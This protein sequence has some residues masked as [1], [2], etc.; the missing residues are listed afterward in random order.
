MR[1][2][3]P[4]ALQNLTANLPP[5]ITRVRGKCWGKRSRTPAP[6]SL[7]GYNRNPLSRLMGLEAPAIS[8]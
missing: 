8:S 5:P 3:A 2:E 1:E 6:G 4:E 7:S